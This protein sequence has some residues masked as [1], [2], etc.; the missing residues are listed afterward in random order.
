MILKR[1]NP[2]LFISFEGPEGSGK[3]THSRRL[4][5][6]L[7]RQGH[8]VLLTR[9]PGGTALGNRLRHLLLQSREEIDPFIELCERVIKLTPIHK[10]M[11]LP[12]EYLF[13]VF[14]LTPELIRTY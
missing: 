14:I 1:R 10:R 2:G 6:W 4:A 5:A 13:L 8:S 12:Y 7:K 3:S 11:P 9:E